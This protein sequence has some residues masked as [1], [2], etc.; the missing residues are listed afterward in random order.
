MAT[1]TST[2]RILPRKACHR[3]WGQRADRAQA[4]SL[5]ADYR[6]P[7]CELPRVTAQRPHEEAHRIVTRFGVGFNRCTA[8]L[9]QIQRDMV[10]AAAQTST[11]LQPTLSHDWPTSRSSSITPSATIEPRCRGH[12][13]S[14]STRLF[15]G[16]AFLAAYSWPAPV[17]RPPPAMPSP[18]PQD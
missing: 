10:F 16:L 8:C 6:A 11:H 13:S 17:L 9:S 4:A 3:P 1:P 2:T 18:H 15:L 14:E 5:R 7:L 12:A